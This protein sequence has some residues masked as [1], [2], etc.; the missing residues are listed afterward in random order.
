MREEVVNTTASLLDSSLLSHS[1]APSF[2]PT[3]TSTWTT[4]SSAFTSA[5]PASAAILSIWAPTSHSVSFSQPSNVSQ[6]IARPGMSTF[7]LMPPC[8][9]P[10]GFA[11]PS[12]SR[13]DPF[14]P[15]TS[16]FVPVSSRNAYSQES[17]S[18]ALNGLGEITGGTQYPALIPLQ[19][20]PHF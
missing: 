20:S 13:N 5:P 3:V 16:S 8:F 7:V 11:H 9:S 17:F 2:T 15:S 6:V 19:I 14:G 12:V 10:F 18:R 4:F 1:I